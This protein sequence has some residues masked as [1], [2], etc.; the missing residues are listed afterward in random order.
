[1]S[2]FYIDPNFRRNIERESEPAS[3]WGSLAAVAIVVG[4][5][6]V[7]G[8]FAGPSTQKATHTPMIETTGSGSNSAR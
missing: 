4:L 2:D 6:V 3:I 7:L 8:I 5:F 1:M